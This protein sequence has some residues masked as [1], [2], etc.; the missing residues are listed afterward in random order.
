LRTPGPATE[1]TSGLTTRVRFPAGLP[2]QSSRLLLAL[3]AAAVMLVWWQAWQSLRQT[4]TVLFVDVGQGDC[5]II[6][7]PGGRSLLIDGGGRRGSSTAPAEVGRWI[8]VPAL[9]R[10]GIRRLDG[11]IATH[12]HD[13]HVGGLD[14]VIAQVPVEMVLDSGQ[15]HPT[16][17]YERLLGQVKARNVPFFRARPGQVFNL[18][19]GVRAEVLHPSPPFLQGTGDDLNNN[20]IVVRLTYGQVSFLFTGDLQQEGEEALLADFPDLASTVLKVAHHG[21]VDAT[22]EEFLRA[23]RP[24]W[25]VISVGR[26]NPFGHPHE[27]LLARLNSMRIRVFRTDIMGTIVMST[28]GRRLKAQWSR[29]GRQESAEMK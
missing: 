14:E 5:I 21:S 10:Q 18:G 3:L 8:I 29:G 12:P 22:S 1:G 15:P 6:H 13:D 9:Y 2:P 28:D 4:L 20:S 27:E 7:S 17:S 25:A 26:R 19:A 24:A 16:P 11:I 23:V